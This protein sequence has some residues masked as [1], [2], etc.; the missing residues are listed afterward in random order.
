MIERDRMVKV[1]NRYDGKVG[2]QI[3]D[4]NGFMREFQPREVK[5]ITFE[6][7]EKLSYDPGGA[8][9]LRNYLVIKDEEVIKALFPDITRENIPEYFY[10][11]D[12]IKYLLT[13]ATLDQFLDCLDFA[14]TGVIDMVKDLAVSMPLNDVNKREAIKNKLGFDVTQAIENAKEPEEEKRVTNNG[15][16]AA[17]VTVGE[18]GAGNAIKQG[19]RVVKKVTE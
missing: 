17:A 3:P 7:L 9:I 14:P 10:T 8:S 16:R 2:Y 15:R 12:E 1:I 13:G 4:T 11:E 18:A 19:R 5:E 6:E